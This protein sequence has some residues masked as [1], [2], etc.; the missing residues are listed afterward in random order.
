MLYSF[1]CKRD[2]CI[3]ERVTEV[4]FYENRTLRR[5]GSILQLVTVISVG[6]ILAGLFKHVF[7]CQEAKKNCLDRSFTFNTSTQQKS[8]DNI[9][10]VYFSVMDA[11]SSMIIFI[12]GGI[13]IGMFIGLVCICGLVYMW[14]R[15]ARVLLIKKV[16]LLQIT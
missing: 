5:V 6:T 2:S 7:L 3:L 1:Q 9:L 14:W 10:S 12:S 11:P 8:E 13:I 16:C 4:G 15:N